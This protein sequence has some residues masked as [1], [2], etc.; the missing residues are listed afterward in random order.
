LGVEILLEK[1]LFS[2]DVKSTPMP[3]GCF[4][5]LDLEPLPVGEG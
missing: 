1:A 2:G 5:I 3:K 4:T